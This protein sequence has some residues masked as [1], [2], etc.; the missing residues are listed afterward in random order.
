MNVFINWINNHEV[1]NPYKMAETRLEDYEENKLEGILGEYIRWSSGDAFNSD[2]SQG[3]RNFLQTIENN[4]D[5]LPRLKKLFEEQFVDEFRDNMR[6]E[7]GD[8]VGE[9]NDNNDTEFETVEQVEEYI[10]NYEM[11]FSEHIYSLESLGYLIGEYNDNV[12][13]ELYAKLIVPLF[14]SHWSGIEGTVDTNKEI[15]DDLNNI[16]SQPLKIRFKTLNVAINATH[17][18]GDMMSHYEDR[19][20]VSKDTLDSLSDMDVTDWDKEL[21]MLGFSFN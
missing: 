17:Q 5:E 9:F 19:Y 7:F 2:R 14:R 4:F 8:D 21:K 16:H 6:N 12:L 15:L 11:N 10:D 3:E 13:E 1:D 18:T 20:D